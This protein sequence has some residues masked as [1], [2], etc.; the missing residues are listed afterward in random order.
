MAVGVDTMNQVMDFYTTQSASLVATLILEEAELAAV[1]EK[2]AKVQHQL[3][4]LG[5]SSG[6]TVR[7]DITISLNVHSVTD[8]LSLELSY[9]V[10]GASWQPAYDMRLACAEQ[11]MPLIY[12]GMVTQKHGEDWIGC[13]LQLHNGTPTIDEIGREAWWE[14]M[15][16]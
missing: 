11:V 12:Y 10:S 5:A 2:I 8:E 3:M 7:R 16:R 15:W 9:V 1:N 14:K 4:M 6:P 13:Q